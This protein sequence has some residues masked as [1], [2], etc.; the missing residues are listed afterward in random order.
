MQQ[1]DRLYG[2]AKTKKKQNLQ[3]SLQFENANKLK[4]RRRNCDIT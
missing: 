4:H 1:L 2:R 3:N